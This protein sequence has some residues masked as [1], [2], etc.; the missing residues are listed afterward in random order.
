MDKD[1][2]FIF[3]RRRIEPFIAFAV[4]IL[5]ILLSVQLMEGN[6]LRNEISQTCGWE[7]EDFRCFCEK[8]EAIAIMNKMN[9]VQSFEFGEVG[10]VQVDR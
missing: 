10:N 2:L 6:E 9:N 8:S 1:Q 3:F 5:L 7:G 4:L